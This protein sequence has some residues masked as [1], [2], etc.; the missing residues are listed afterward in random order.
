[1]VR[2]K[3]IALGLVLAVWAG[4]AAAV[5]AWAGIRVVVSIPP[6]KYFVEKVGGHEVEVTVMVPPGADAHTYEPRPGQMAALAGADLYFTIGVEFEQ[7]WANKFRA[8]NKGLV[9]I[10]T[11]REVNRIPMESGSGHRAAE[12]EDHGHRGLDPHIW[13]SPALVDLQAQAVRDGLARAAP[14]STSVLD[15]N[16]ADFQEEIRQLD[17]ELRDAFRGLGE[18]RRVLVFHPAWGYFCRDYGL[19][20]VAVEHEGKS[21]TAKGLQALIKQARESGAKIV[22]VQPQFST[23]A[24][25]ILARA[26]GGR[27]VPLDPLALDWAGNLRQA[28]QQLRK[29]MF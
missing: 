19:T 17:R 20:Q 24:A 13:L 23:R 11:A 25:G 5:P 9:F 14:G 4:F 2:R 22:F 15:Q 29:G 6:Q 26:I 21:P 27:V 7:A 10:D 8:A 28:A 18:N 1:M 16:L 3:A 12:E